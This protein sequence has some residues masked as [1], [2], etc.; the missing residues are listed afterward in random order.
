MVFA[1]GRSLHASGNSLHFS[2]SA[3]D[4]VYD[5]YMGTEDIRADSP[6]WI[7]IASIWFSFGLIDAL[8][9]VFVM[10]SEGMHHAWLILFA[11]VTFSWLPWVVA[12]P[13]IL[14]LSRRFPLVKPI[15]TVTW[16]VHVSAC[17]ATG[18]VSSAWTSCLYFLLNPY[19]EPAPS[20]Y[21]Q[22]WF[23]KFSNGLL[24]YVVLYAGMLMLNYVLDSRARLAFRETEAARLNEQLVIAQL[25]ALRQ[26]I[27]PHFLFNTL[28]SVAGLVREGRNDSAVIMIAG[29]SDLLRRMLDD[30]TR[31]Q[32]PLQEEMAFAQKYLDIQKV[33]F[34]DRLQVDVDVPRELNL[35]QVPSLILQPMVENAI[36]HGI[37][38]RAKGG[39]IRIAASRS[40]G[41]LTLSVFND[42][43]SLPANWETTCPGIGISNVRTRLQTLYGNACDIRM[44]NQSSGGVEV[45]VSLPF[46]VLPPSREP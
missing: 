42:G 31:Q 34:I 45:S 36:K 8:E 19:P 15:S 43:P 1:K 40:S 32:V 33:R 44:R 18:I 11:V 4:K 41:M 25:H 12:T 17:A 37:A 16:L 39:A 24:T 6:R 9:T 29:L 7:G 21:L 26:Q 35:A 5:S 3:R 20:P 14:R 2:N 13:L 30:S 27:E 10:R 46:V 23:D 22:L 28:N 38:K